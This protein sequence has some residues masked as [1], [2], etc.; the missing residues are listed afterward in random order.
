MK[1]I[2]IILGIIC[3]TDVGTCSGI[4]QSICNPGS[5]NTFYPNGQLKACTLKENL[6]VNGVT[7]KQYETINL[8]E[9]GVS[10]S[11]FL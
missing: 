11:F 9:T 3:I 6:S 7:C 10:V 1:Y 8:Y 2:I 5:A 4:D